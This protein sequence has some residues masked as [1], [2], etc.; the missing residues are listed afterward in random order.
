MFRFSHSGIW[1]D[2]RIP[3]PITLKRSEF[4]PTTDRLFKKCTFYSAVS[5]PVYLS[6]CWS[7]DIFNAILAL[8]FYTRVFRSR[9]WLSVNYYPCLWHIKLV[10][11]IMFPRLLYQISK[12]NQIRFTKYTNAVTHP[13][14]SRRAL[15]ISWWQSNLH[16]VLV[17]VHPASFLRMYLLPGRFELNLPNLFARQR[18]ITSR[19]FL[20]YTTYRRRLPQQTITPLSSRNLFA[21]STV[22]LWP[23]PFP[24]LID[25]LPF[26]VAAYYIM[27]L[28]TYLHFKTNRIASPK[29]LNLTNQL[30]FQ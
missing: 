15:T 26:E 18:I 5:A 1:E 11:E 22:H 14:M 12:Q 30:S 8:Q 16:Y 2:G 27:Y 20:K 13:S 24:S 28:W 19:L 7:L 9:E 23:P 21:R 10:V 4:L 3:W 25:M 6:L 29:L 17:P